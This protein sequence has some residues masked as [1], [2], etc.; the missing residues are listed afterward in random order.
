MSFLV[1]PAPAGWRE[2]PLAEA[3]DVV[4][5]PSNSMIRPVDT[6][7]VPVEVVA[8]KHLMYGRIADSGTVLVTAEA[9]A[10]LDRYRLIPGDLI[11]VRTGDLGKQALAG[12][13]HEGWVTGTACFRL[14]PEPSVESRYLL[15]YMRHPAVRDWI[16]R[17][18]STAT[19]PT[20][21]LS[22]LRTLPVLVPPPAVQET[23]GDTM[24]AL[25]DKVALHREIVEVTER[26]RDSLFPL[27][28]KKPS[29]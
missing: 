6:D 4:A 8:P 26:L 19:V 16:A 3:C 14:R 2:I 10:R 29:H 27:L 11:C 5:G 7:G 24:S 15:H 1:G 23:I 25:D 13:E 9:S 28:L 21:T 22:T 18:A 12:P 17:N 20:L